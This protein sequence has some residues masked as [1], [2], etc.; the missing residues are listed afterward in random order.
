[1]GNP[2]GRAARARRA[3]RATCGRWGRAGTLRFSV[4]SGGAQRARGRVR[5][6]RPASA[7]S[8]ASRS[9]RP[10]GW[11]AT[12]GAA[13]SSRAWCCGT[14]G[15]CAPAPIEVLG[16]PEDYLRGG[17]RR[18]STRACSPAHEA[19]RQGRPS[20]RRPGRAGARPSRRRARSPC[21]RDARRGRRR[22]VLARLRRRRRGG[23]PGCSARAGGFALIAYA[24]ARARSGDRRAASCHLVALDPP[25]VPRPRATA[26]AG[27]GFTHLAWGEPELRFAQ[28]MHELE[29]GLRASLVALYRALRLRERV[30]GE[31]LEHLLRGDG[32]HGRPA[33]LA[34]R[35]I[36][37]LAEL[38]LVSLD[39]DLPALAIASAQ[40]TELERSPAYR[41]Y[42]QRYE[43]GRRFLS[44]A[45]HRRRRLSRT[46]RAGHGSALDDGRRT[47]RRSARV[48]ASRPPV[49]RRRR[50]RGRARRRSSAPS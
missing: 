41:V 6:R 30:A 39:R 26:R 15:P 27:R 50:R 37:V 7:A 29:Y 44:S 32:P 23:S 9:T 4:S 21:W 40:P 8:P 3:V 20:G 11:S 12:S 13:R 18:S 31:E 16:E 42:A 48:S 5:L 24:R 17:A 38:E 28:Q 19:R 49:D 25:A 14:R 34:G 22:S 33:R 47:A 43:D 1:M 35:L 2:R 45:N 46:R 36:R 10:S